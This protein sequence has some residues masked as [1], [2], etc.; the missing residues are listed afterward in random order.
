MVF[1]I[2]LS[3]KTKRELV[4]IS[5]QL[6]AYTVEKMKNNQNE[7]LDLHLMNLITTPHRT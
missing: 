3:S 2:K 4:V 6:F 5:Q 1:I 7:N